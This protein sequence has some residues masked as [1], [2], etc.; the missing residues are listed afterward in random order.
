MIDG[1]L[2]ITTRHLPHW[3]ISGAQYFVTFRTKNGLLSIDEQILTLEHIKSG[4]EKFYTLFAVIVMPDH[5]H[6]LIEPNE[7]YSLSEIMKGIK[8][9]SAKKINSLRKTNGSVWQAESLDRI[10]RD[11]NEFEEKLRYMYNNPLKNGLT[12]DPNTYHGWSCYYEIL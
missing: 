3:T 6:L 9:V 1:D 12:D 7:K 5:V 11:Q 10:V 8:G 4:H 2:Q